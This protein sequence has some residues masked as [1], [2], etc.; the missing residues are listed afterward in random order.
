MLAGREI[1]ITSNAIPTNKIDV[2][3]TLKPAPAT[4]AD[5]ALAE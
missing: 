2:E 1:G 5:T 3:T 4:L